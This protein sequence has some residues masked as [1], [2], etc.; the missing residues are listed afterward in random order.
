MVSGQRQ[1]EAAAGAKSQCAE[2]N[3]FERHCEIDRG[4]YRE[5]IELTP[6]DYAVRLAFLGEKVRRPEAVLALHRRCSFCLHF[7]GNGCRRL[8]PTCGTRGRRTQLFI[9]STGCCN[10]WG[11]NLLPNCQ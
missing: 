9:D 11:V 2:T 6:F 3:A 1:E 4:I 8:E 10:R 5:P 7:T